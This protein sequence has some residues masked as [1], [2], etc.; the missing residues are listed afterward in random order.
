MGESAESAGRLIQ[1]LAGLASRLAEREVV[2]AS[3]HCDWRG[4]GSWALEAQR[5]PAADAY[6]DAL[7]AGQSGAPGPEVVRV[8]WDGREQRLTIEKAR[9]APLSS[10]G[11]WT[12]AREETLRDARAAIR[13]A[14]DYLVRWARGQA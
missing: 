8:S 7:L 6:G 5:G 3:L 9:T 10:P 12:R 4:F 13:F 11:P 2:V 14:E 1:E